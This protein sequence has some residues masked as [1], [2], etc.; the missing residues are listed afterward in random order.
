[1]CG[2]CFRAGCGW[3]KRRAVP[4]PTDPGYVHEVRYFQNLR[5]QTLHQRG[6][7]AAHFSLEGESQLSCHRERRGPSPG[8]PAALHPRACHR[9]HSLQTPAPTWVRIVR[10]DVRSN[11][12]SAIGSLSCSLWRM[13]SSRSGSVP[14]VNSVGMGFVVERPQFGCALHRTSAEENKLKGKSNQA[15]TIPS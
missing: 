5:P 3:T 2:A 12:M 1:M 6:V 11:V 9:T 7:G 13:S 14:P 10:L 15:L 8:C 4:V